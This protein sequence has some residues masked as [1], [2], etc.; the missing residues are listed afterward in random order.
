MAP[1]CAYEIH[2][3]SWNSCCAVLRHCSTRSVGDTLSHGSELCLPYL[4]LSSPTSFG[5]YQRSA[6]WLVSLVGWLSFFWQSATALFGGITKIWLR[7]AV[8]QNYVS[9][10][11]AVRCWNPWLCCDLILV[12]LCGHTAMSIYWCFMWHL[13][14]LCS[15][16]NFFGMLKQTNI[17][18]KLCTLTVSIDV[19]LFVRVPCE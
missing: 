12:L 7:P 1:P 15:L 13:L 3:C 19:L 4:F 11:V 16:Y 18:F 10:C 9:V 6:S 17:Y 14:D 5:T 8:F 2:D